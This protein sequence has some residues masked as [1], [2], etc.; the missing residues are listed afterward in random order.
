MSDLVVTNQSLDL[1]HPVSKPKR[2]RPAGQFNYHK[3]CVLRFLQEYTATNDAPYEGT[4]DELSI[5]IG[6]W[7]NDAGRLGVSPRQVARY[8]RKLQD[9]TTS[10]GK[11]RIEIALHRYKGPQGQYVTK[12]R[13][14]VNEAQLV[15]I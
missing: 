7:G 2:G 1:S 6:A 5:A 13:I 14:H 8:L 3:S 4:N 11:P 12:R 10:D 9:E 15:Q